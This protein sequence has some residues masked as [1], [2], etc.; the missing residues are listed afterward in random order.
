MSLALLV[1][2]MPTPTGLTM[3]VTIMLVTMAS[4]ASHSSGRGRGQNQPKID[5]GRCIMTAPFS[6]VAQ[7]L[8]QMIMGDLMYYLNI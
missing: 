6:F 1:S 7:L 2:S 4:R 3:L 8:G 5:R